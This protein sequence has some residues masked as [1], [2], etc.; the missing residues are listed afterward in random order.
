[1]GGETVV[2]VEINI[3]APFLIEYVPKSSGDTPILANSDPYFLI[4]S[5]KMLLNRSY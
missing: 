1:M 2:P 5:I 3:A 4:V